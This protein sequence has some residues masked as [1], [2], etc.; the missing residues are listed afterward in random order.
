MIELSPT[1]LHYKNRLHTGERI[2]VWRSIPELIAVLFGLGFIALFFCGPAKS[3]ESMAIVVIA[4]LPIVIYVL[5]RFLFPGVAITATE[6]ITWDTFGRKD[7]LP[8][9]DISAIM[10]EYGTGNSWGLYTS[11]QISVSL[12]DP[13]HASEYTWVYLWEGRKDLADAICAELIEQHQFVKLDDWPSQA[14]YPAF[15]GVWGKHTE[16]HIST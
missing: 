10:L 4:I 3:F 5:L 13:T 9:V 11:W 14:G 15:W 6:F 16:T 8:I 1:A 12:P 7:V 2:P